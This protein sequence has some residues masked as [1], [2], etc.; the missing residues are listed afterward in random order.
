MCAVR[1]VT[2]CAGTRAER[3]GEHM[4]VFVCVCVFWFLSYTCDIWSESKWLMN[5]P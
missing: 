1:V 5:I 3:E 2:A 4:C